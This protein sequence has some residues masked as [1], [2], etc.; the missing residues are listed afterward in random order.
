MIDSLS[1]LVRNAL[2]I[3]KLEKERPDKMPGNISSPTTSPEAY[4][5]FLQGKAAFYR[6]DFPLAI[7]CFLHALTVDSSLVSVYTNL[8][9]SYYN[10]F[11]FSLGRE[12]MIRGLEKYDLLSL[13]DKI[14]FDAFYAIYFKTFNERIRYLRQLLDLDDQ[15]PMTYFNIGDCYFEM[16]E[17]EKAIPE[18]EKALEIFHKWDTKPYWAAFYY[19]LG[20]SYHRSG[21]YKK[22]QKLYKKADRDFPDDPGLLDQHAWLELALGDTVSADWYLDRFISVKR[23]ESWSEGRIASY[24][25]YVYNMAEMP[26]SEYAFLSKALSLEP[27]NPLR[28]N[29]LA[30]FLINTGRNVEEGLVLVNRALEFKPDD[31]R[32]LHTEGW[33]LYKQGKYTEALNQLERSWDLRPLYSHPLYL[34]LEEAKKAVAALN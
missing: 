18:F 2:I 5:Y 30:Y 28:M 27:D 9:A 21:Q 20:I 7:E 25:A 3:F 26:D 23:E 29:N 14:S 6:N 22:E 31:Y 1:V 17:W 10:Q 33:G 8:S 16:A 4:R 11:N 12:W 32:F 24:L 13:K 34:H 15:N 19:E